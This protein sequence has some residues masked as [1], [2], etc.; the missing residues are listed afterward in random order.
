M[1]R[2]GR[3]NPQPGKQYPNRSDMRQPAQAV[4]NQTYGERGKQLEAQKVVPLP[5]AQARPVGPITQQAQ[6]TQQLGMGAPPSI[7]LNAP[8]GRPNEPITAGLPTGAGPGPEA[9]NLPPQASQDENMLATLRGL[10]QAFPNPDVAR[11]IQAVQARVQQP[12]QPLPEMRNA[13]PEPG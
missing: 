5:T 6:Q 3:R 7:P 10:Y 9:L 12:G 13:L 1:P 4:K 8:T 11:L 2:G